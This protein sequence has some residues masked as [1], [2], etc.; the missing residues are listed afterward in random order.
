MWGCF[1]SS[2][3]NLIWL[4]CLP[5]WA[6][7]DTHCIVALPV[8]S[9]ILIYNFRFAPCPSIGRPPCTCYFLIEQVKPPHHLLSVFF[10]KSLYPS[11]KHTSYIRHPIMYLWSQRDSSCAHARLLF[12]S[13][14][15]NASMRKHTLQEGTPIR[16]ICRKGFGHFDT[17]YLYVRAGG[18]ARNLLIL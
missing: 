14:L 7:A 4:L 18:Y 10:Y 8:I 2:V 6:V 5:R 11:C 16:Q 13:H 1:F 9:L 17:L 15:H 12:S 3:G